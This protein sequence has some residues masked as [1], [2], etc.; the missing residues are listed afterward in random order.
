MTLETSWSCSSPPFPPWRYFRRRRRRW[1]WTG[2]RS[3]SC[4]GRGTRHTCSA[5]ALRW[6]H[7]QDHHWGG[8][9]EQ[10]ENIKQDNQEAENL[11]HLLLAGLAP[12][13]PAG[14]RDWPEDELNMFM[15]RMNSYNIMNWW[16]WT[17]GTHR[18]NSPITHAHLGP[19]RRPV[20]QWQAAH[21]PQLRGQKNK[22][23][24][25]SFFQDNLSC[26]FSPSRFCTDWSTVPKVIIFVVDISLYFARYLWS[27]S[28]QTWPR[29]P[30]INL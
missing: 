4:S 25:F 30:N 3:S 19:H 7:R 18:K 28:L 14:A 26:V 17:W 1:P 10:G 5:T 9:E 8:E 24:P 11:N 15:M 22:S 12:G 2:S 29:F 16:I 6:D 27:I 23:W 21:K 20:L 13:K